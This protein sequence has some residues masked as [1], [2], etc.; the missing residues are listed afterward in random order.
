MSRRAVLWAAFVLVHLG[1]AVLGFVEPNQPMGDVYLVYEP[2][3]A[4]AA[5][6]AGV[7]GITEDWVYPAFAL[8]PLLTTHVLAPLFGSYT[9]AW[10][11]LVTVLDAVAFAVLVG[12]GRSRGRASAAWFWLAFIAVL[13]PVGMYRLDGITVPLVLAGCLW[14][15]ARPWLAGVLLAVATWIKVWPAAILLAALV[16]VRRRLP[17]LAAGAAVSAVTVAAVALAG[18]AANVT[19]FISDQT[20]RGLQI[21]APVSGFYLWRVVLGLDDSEVAYDR[22]L[23]TFQVSG[24][25]SDTVSALMTP[26]LF[27]ALGVVVVIGVLRRRAGAG[28]AGLFPPL[29][30]ASVLVFIVFNKVGSPQYLTWIIVPVAIG[31]LLDR[32]RWW[33]PACLALVTAGL[34]HLVY[35]LS[36]DR[37]LAGEAVATAALT[38]RNA[39]LLLL[40]V[41]SVV[42]VLRARPLIGAPAPRRADP[43][44]LSP[45]RS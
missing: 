11:V 42:L 39:L 21:E 29:A 37:L 20:G 26:A 12:R 30:L 24:P 23:L 27:A 25:G 35:P 22:G 44:V 5:A 17:L 9:V 32:R 2:W 3:S 13:G 6:G 36:Y 1:V 38:V 45:D 40:L 15:I 16:A 43:T 41:Y 34:T 14:L 4:R 8:V 18:G 33:V 7:V 31:V 28:F 10:A 19:S